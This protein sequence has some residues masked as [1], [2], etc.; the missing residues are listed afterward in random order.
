SN[1][2]FSRCNGYYAMVEAQ[3]R[4]T[5]HCH[6]LVWLEGNPTPQELRD[7]M[8]LNPEV[9]DNMFRWLESIISCELPTTTEV[10][11]EKDGPL[12]PP[13]IPAGWENPRLHKKPE[14]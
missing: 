1:G 11:I 6:M 4:G 14:V 13:E 7:R 5:L 3:G 2:L 10:I 9:Q 8:R 12:L